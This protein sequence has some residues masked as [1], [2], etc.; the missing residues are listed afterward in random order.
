MATVKYMVCDRCGVANTYHGVTMHS[1]VLTGTQ[2]DVCQKCVEVIDRVMKNNINEGLLIGAKALEN[3][4]KS[5]GDDRMLELC[6]CSGSH[7]SKTLR[8][9]EENISGAV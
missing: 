8:H 5:V 1:L 2:Y 7:L 3:L 6:G 4:Q 9:I